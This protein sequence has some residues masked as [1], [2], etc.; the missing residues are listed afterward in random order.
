MCFPVSKIF[1]FS[2]YS[3]RFWPTLLIP[4]SLKEYDT[5]ISQ[6]WPAEDTQSLYGDESYGP[7]LDF[8]KNISQDPVLRLEYRLGL[9]LPEDML[10]SPALYTTKEQQLARFGLV[11]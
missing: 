5:I 7:L 9:Q 11:N 6:T 2:G 10:K 3:F 8:V 4:M 1:T